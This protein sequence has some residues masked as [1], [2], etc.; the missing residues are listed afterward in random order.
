VIGWRVQEALCETGD[1]PGRP[2]GLCT[3][4][5]F[6]VAH[7]WM[8]ASPTPTVAGEGFLSRKYSI[9]TCRNFLLNKEKV[10]CPCYSSSYCM[11]AR[12]PP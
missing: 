11:Y 6:V 7:D 8:P 1:I 5:Y 4:A 9:W 12:T 2:V 10:A 3:V